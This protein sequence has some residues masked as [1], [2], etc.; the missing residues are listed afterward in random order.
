MGGS[1]FV[2]VSGGAECHAERCQGSSLGHGPDLG[3]PDDLSRCPRK[4]DGDR[5]DIEFWPNDLSGCPGEKDGQFQH[6]RIEDHLPGR[7]GAD[8]GNFLPFSLGSDDLSRCLGSDHRHEQP[9][10]QQ[11][12]V[13]GCV[14]SPDGIGHVEEVSGWHQGN[15]SRLV[16]SRN[17]AALP[18]RT[19]RLRG[20]GKHPLGRR[21]VIRMPLRQSCTCHEPADHPFRKH[22][23]HHSYRQ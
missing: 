19:P 21:V 16:Q 23:P 17:K 14:G 7:A 9:S 6:E 18:Q 4:D 10:R 3:R 2:F 22:P 20:M 13:P 5:H 12:H 15:A 11:P 8:H 1:G